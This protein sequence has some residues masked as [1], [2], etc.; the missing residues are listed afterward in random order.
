[1]K[2]EYHYKKAKGRQDQFM[3]KIV[4][5]LMEYGTWESYD[6]VWDMPIKH[7]AILKKRKKA[8][9]VFATYS[10]GDPKAKLYTEVTE[11]EKDSEKA[12]SLLLR[13]YAVPVYRISHPSKIIDLKICIL[14]TIF[15]KL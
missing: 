12:V 13:E 7:L 4:Q 6:K 11:S 2:K 9:I 14:E 1:M 3:K 10:M 15:K 5:D 8:F